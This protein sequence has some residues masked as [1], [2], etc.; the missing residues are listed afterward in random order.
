MNGKLSEDPI[1]I[2]KNIDLKCA[3]CN[4]PFTLKVGAAV[5]NFT[6]ELM[7]ENCLVRC[8]YQ[9]CTSDIYF[10]VDPKFL[11]RQK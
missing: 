10:F 7:E 3:N 8:F 1:R 5:I 6:D 9:C 2:L 4:S 11:D